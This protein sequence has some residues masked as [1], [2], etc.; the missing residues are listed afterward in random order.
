MIENASPFCGE[1]TGSCKSSRTSSP[2]FRITSDHWCAMAPNPTACSFNH[3]SMAGSRFTAPLNR[4]NSVLIVAPLS[5]F[6]IH[7]YIAV[8]YMRRLQLVV[9]GGPKR[10]VPQWPAFGP[11]NYLRVM[12]FL[13]GL[14][15]GVTLVT[16]RLRDFVENKVDRG[17]TDI[18]PLQTVRGGVNV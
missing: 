17:R 1:G 16:A 11:S 9:T 13:S 4:S 3:A 10:V 15:G 6:G 5:A 12:S 18:K 2:H 7:G 8:P 14:S